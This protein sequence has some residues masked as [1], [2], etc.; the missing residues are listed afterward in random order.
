MELLNNSKEVIFMNCDKYRKTR[1]ETISL[2]CTPEEKTLIYETAILE[3]K[4]IN[5]MVIDLVKQK[6]VKLKEGVL[7]ENK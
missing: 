1:T 5:Q 2:R 4:K 7:Y 6:L 3:N